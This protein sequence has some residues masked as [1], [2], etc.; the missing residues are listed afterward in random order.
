MKTFLLI[1]ISGLILHL[2]NCNTQN[3]TLHNGL[4]EFR[5]DTLSLLAGDSIKFWDIVNSHDT[6]NMVQGWIISKNKKLTEYYYRDNKRLLSV[7]GGDVFIGEVNI[8]IV[9][10]TLL[11]PELNREFVIK[12][13]T[14]DTLIVQKI[15]KIG[16]ASQ[17]IYVKSKNQKDMPRM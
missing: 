2:E 5:Q 14:E 11:I 10:D 12:K 7:Y 1:F 3:T 15:L 13:I 4:A 6:S 16:M 8:E 9:Q 17:M